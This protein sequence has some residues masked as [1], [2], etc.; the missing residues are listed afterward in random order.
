MAAATFVTAAVA[1]YAGAPPDE[2]AAAM[3]SG[4]R[5]LRQNARMIFP[6]GK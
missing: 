6:F 3:T 1:E 4:A 5:Q 2:R